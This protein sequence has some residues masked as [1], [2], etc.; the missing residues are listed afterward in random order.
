[1]NEQGRYFPLS[2]STQRQD[3][4]ELVRKPLTERGWTM[5]SADYFSR[6][7]N[8]HCIKIAAQRIQALEDAPLLIAALESARA[9]KWI[10]VE[11]KPRDGGEVFVHGGNKTAI[12]RYSFDNK[13]WYDM[14]NMRIL[15]TH[16]QAIE[17]PLHRQTRNT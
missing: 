12:G 7:K 2:D 1:M 4:L 11:T 9:D 14:M 17:F 3:I 13:C 8:C 10:P 16:W 15:P 5:I 6:G